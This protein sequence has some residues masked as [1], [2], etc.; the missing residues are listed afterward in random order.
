VYESESTV[1]LVMEYASGG[2]LFDY[3][4][5]INDDDSRSGIDGGLDESEARRIFHQ[6]LSAVQ[7]LHE[8]SYSGYNFVFLFKRIILEI[9]PH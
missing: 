6:L 3:I 9:I 4:N 7:Y 5:S 2:E 1:T 8:V